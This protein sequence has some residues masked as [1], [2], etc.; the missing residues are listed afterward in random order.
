MAAGEGRELVFNRDS[1]RCNNTSVMGMDG[2][3]DCTTV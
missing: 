3:D 2:S 1:L